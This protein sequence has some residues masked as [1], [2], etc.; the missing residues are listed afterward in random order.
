MIKRFFKQNIKAKLVA[1]LIAL[2]AWVFVSSNQSLMGKF[3]NQISVKVSNLSTDYVAFLDDEDVE[4]Y[5]MAEPSVWNTLSKDSFVAT[6]DVAGLSEGTFDLEVKVSSSVQ[7]VQITRVEPSKVFVNIEKIVTKDLPVNVKIDGDPADGMVVGET[8]ADIE[9]VKVRGPESLIK[10]VSE[11]TAEVKLN[12]ESNDFT[13]ETT[14]SALSENNSKLDQI[15]FLPDKVI[16]SVSIVKGGNNKTVGVKLNA[17]NSLPDNYYISRITLSPSTV[18]I[19]GQRSVLSGINYIETESFDLSL[20]SSNTSKDLL[21]IL[22]S[23]VA[24]QKGSAPSTRV[25]IEIAKMSLG[26]S[27]VPTISYTNLSPGLRVVS[28]DPESVKITAS[29]ADQNLLVSA[30]FQLEIN[31]SGLGIGNH[32]IPIS[33]EMIKSSGNLVINS[34]LPTSIKVVISN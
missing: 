25:N 21:L 11:A 6:V 4:I 31:L 12:G 10:M 27:I 8:S 29:S 28:T 5:L 1:I 9:N 19:T 26:T 34:I 24:L 14:L 22:P 30:N 23:G 18:D 33:A 15:T 32:I 16:V 2:I 7:G 13:R 17:K 3:P 20:I